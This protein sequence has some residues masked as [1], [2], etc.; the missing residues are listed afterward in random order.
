MMTQIL[1][2]KCELLAR[3]TERTPLGPE[4][5]VWLPIGNAWTRRI[6]VDV[7]TRLAYSQYKTVVTDRFVFGEHV[8]I[9]IG[10]HRISFHGKTYEPVESGMYLDGPYVTVLVKEVLDGS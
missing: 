7:A 4:A 10:T 8:D 3:Q 1:R 5:E 6:S 2:E 9:R